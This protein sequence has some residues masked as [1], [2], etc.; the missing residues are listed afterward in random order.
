MHALTELDPDKLNLARLSAGKLM[1]FK[2]YFPSGGLLLLLI[3]KFHDDVLDVLEVER[4]PLPKRA[5]ERH[6]LDELT[7]VEL[8]TV[9]G[10]TSALLDTFT[11][12]MDDPALSR[13]L[14]QYQADL[15]AQKAERAQISTE[16][17]ATA[18]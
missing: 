17:G 9:A 1:T 3:G 14:R 8:D 5:P 6:P 15:N 2:E 16:I 4:G 12:Y 11:P 13:L 18:S 10:A 7:S